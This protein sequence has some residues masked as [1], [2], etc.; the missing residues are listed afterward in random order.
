M[1]IGIGRTWDEENPSFNME[2]I[3][4]FWKRTMT[5]LPEGEVL[6]RNLFED[7]LVGHLHREGSMVV[8]EAEDMRLE[9]VKLYITIEA[10]STLKAEK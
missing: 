2:R 9:N 10:L 4:P 7:Y 3:P 6:A 5:D 8:C 1:A